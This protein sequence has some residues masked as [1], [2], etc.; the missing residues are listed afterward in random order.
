L[1]LCPLAV[2]PEKDQSFAGPTANWFC[3]LWARYNPLALP[4]TH[5]YSDGRGLCY[6]IPTVPH[7]SRSEA[8]AGSRRHRRHS[9]LTTSSTCTGFHSSC[10]SIGQK[11]NSPAR[12]RHD[13]L[14]LCGV[15]LRP[16]RGLHQGNANAGSGSGRVLLRLHDVH[17]A[18]GD[19]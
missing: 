1:A 19:D 10:S 8:A 17:S 14:S 12:F 2:I 6:R 18:K 5:H 16:E 15:E 9:T 11:D 4:L 7:C 13:H 3:T